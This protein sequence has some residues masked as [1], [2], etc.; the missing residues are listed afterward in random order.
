MVAVADAYYDFV[1]NSLYFPAGIL[2]R[3]FYNSKVPDYMNFAGIGVV[4]GHELT[5]GFD[6]MGRHLNWKG[7]PI[8]APASSNKQITFS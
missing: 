2:Q 3:V 6:N 7:T 5:H 4:I 1:T 8:I